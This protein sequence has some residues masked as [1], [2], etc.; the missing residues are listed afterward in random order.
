MSLD[1][2]MSFFEARFKENKNVE[3]IR[4]LAKVY[5]DK[6]ISEAFDLYEMIEDEN[7]MKR[8]ANHHFMTSTYGEKKFFERLGVKPSKKMYEEKAEYHLSKAKDTMDKVGDH[9][10]SFMDFEKAVFSY[11]KADKMDKVNEVVNTIVNL[12][13]NPKYSK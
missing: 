11:A 7:N 1:N 3:E 8:I 5:E 6:D 2:I 13:N 10:Y 12:G 9:K 4:T